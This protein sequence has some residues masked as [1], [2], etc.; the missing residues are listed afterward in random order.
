MKSYLSRLISVFTI[1]MFIFII[2]TFWL[3]IDELA[4]KGLDIIIISKFLLYYSPKLIPLVLPL[5]VLLA[6]LMTYGTLSENYEFAAMKST[7]ISLQRAMLGLVI[8]HIFLGIGTFY[9]SN[10]VIPYGELKSYNL[11]RNLAKLEPTLAIREGIFNEIGKINIKVDRKYGDNDRFLEGVIIHEYTPNSENNIVIKAERGEMKS[12]TSDPNLKLVLYNGNRYEEVIPKKSKDR[13]RI[14]HTKVAF[15]EYEMNIDLSKFNNINLE[16]E[17]YKSTFR[18]QKI[19]QLKESID[20]L[21]KSFTEEQN[22]FSENFGRQSVLSRTARKNEAVVT[23]DSLPGNLFQFIITNEIWKQSKVIDE[24][25]IKIRSSIRNLNTKRSSFFAYQK[26]INLHKIT[27]HE[28]Y[29]LLF[30]SLLLFII[31]AALGAIIRKGGLGLPLVL[32]VL[33][34]LTYHYIG[35][36]SKNAAED[37]SISPFLASWLSTL[38]LAPFAIILTRRASSDKGFVS[39]SNLYYPIE[40]KIKHLP[41]FKKNK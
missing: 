27:L 3:F 24:S 16:E 6:S 22:A 33:I 23:I 38:I 20:T 26:L 17:S 2:Q 1:C 15:E 11:R 4:G 7:G 10:H 21:Q 12:E 19:E 36:F 8:F 35:L 30:A 39:L 32:A 18:M 41:F 40:E 28:K 25:R 34:F 5:S 37:N 13:E 9:F 31:G 14:P 29:T